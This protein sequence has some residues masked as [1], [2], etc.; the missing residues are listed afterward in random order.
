MGNI[1][2]INTKILT[3]YPFNGI[4]NIKNLDSHLLRIGKKSYENIDIHYIGYF[5]IKRI[6]D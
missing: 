1:K 5:T 6:G 4:I 2:Q 3:Y